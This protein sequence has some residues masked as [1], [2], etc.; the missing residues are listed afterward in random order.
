M[1]NNVSV[2]SNWQSTDQFKYA[3]GR[4]N[5]TKYDTEREGLGSK[6]FKTHC[7]TYIDIA[8]IDQWRNMFVQMETRRVFVGHF[9]M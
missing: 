6:R 2:V 5:T 8:E 3:N 1:K 7:V 9:L 4:Q